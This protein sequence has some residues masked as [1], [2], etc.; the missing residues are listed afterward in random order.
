MKPHINFLIRCGIVI[1]LI[2][3]FIIISSNTDP[4]EIQTPTANPSRITPVEPSEPTKKEAS[5]DTPT[6]E[7]EPHA[8]TER[9]TERNALSHT[10]S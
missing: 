1:V 10:Q 7:N 8:A 3:A 5:A 6:T 2:L 9:M 4:A